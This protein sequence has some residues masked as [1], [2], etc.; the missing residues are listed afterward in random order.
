MEILGVKFAPLNVPLNRRLETLAAALWILIFA[1]G[2]FAGYVLTAYFLF[3][4]QT[5]RYFV[6][7]YFVWMY[8]DWNKFNVGKIRRKFLQWIRSCAW[9][10]YFCNYFPIKLVKTTDLDP[11]KLYLFCNFPHGTIPSGVYGA[12]GT[13]IIGR[14]EL[15][16]GLEFRV[17]ILDQFFRSPLFR[18]YCRINCALGSSAE[19]IKQHLSTRPPPPYT[20][21]A[22][23]LI[24]GG[25]AEVFESKPGTYRILIKRRKGFVKLALQNGNPLVPVCSFGETDIF[26]QVICPDGSY[27]R[28][29]Q[30]FIRKKSGIP[31]VLQ[32]GRGF[33]QYTFGLIPRRKPI[34]VVVGSPMEL[35]K[36]EEP[37]REQVGEYHEKFVN[38]LVNF[39]E[40][41]KHKYIENA[42]SVHLEF[43]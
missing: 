39:F 19:C 3:F 2:Y 29:L 14:R 27:T 16:P 4:T 24:P 42:D 22:T 41:E 13:D 32:N 23:V 5:M 17:V 25:A 7:L 38:H 28:R 26:D 18:E 40:N 21:R 43:V 9:N 20:G 30:E 37:T 34:T 15:F 8:Y 12:F 1:F 10:R 36:I 11:N 31:L 35:P 6:L 33:F